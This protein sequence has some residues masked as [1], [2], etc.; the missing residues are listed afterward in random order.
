MKICMVC[1]SYPP[2]E[3]SGATRYYTDVARKFSERG[4]SVDVITFLGN[5]MKKSVKKD[6][7]VTVHRLPYMEW[8]DKK[9]LENKSKK[10][11]RYLDRLIK[12]K[13]ID[14]ISSQHLYSWGALGP[15]Y[16][17]ATNLASIHHKI[18]NILTIHTD[19]SD[20]PENINN[21]PIKHLFWN[22]I[23]AVSKNSAEKVHS[24]GVPIK[25]IVDIYPGVD[26]EKFRPDLGKKWLRSRIDVKETDIL[27]LFAGRITDAK[28]V[29]ELLKAFS[30]VVRENKNVKLLLAAGRAPYLG[31]EEEFQQLIQ[32]TYEKAK[33][34][35]IRDNI[36]IQP[37]RLEEMPFVYNG[38][39]IFVLPSR[40]EGFG[41]VYVEAMAC[42][43]P[44]IG[45]STG[46]VPE[47]ITNEKD[48]FLVPPEDATELAKKIEFLVKNEKR[49]KQMGSAG[50]E[51]VKQNFDLD[52]KIEKL[53][54]VYSSTLKKK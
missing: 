38:A 35:G 15:G 25:K 47:I 17:L 49:R 42:G 27:V 41:L 6:G 14:L 4:I 46:G 54:G 31:T 48:G 26:L 8:V 53:I 29:P 44:V 20:D 3:V 24:L 22:K 10:L 5:D 18:P 45:T 30:V 32:N 33:I 9:D 12:R 7:K 43:L 34:L 40:R 28:G 19:L 2:R 51:K 50:I 36:I 23:I 52:K 16:S 39:D 1:P 37:F 11:F 13:N 21:I